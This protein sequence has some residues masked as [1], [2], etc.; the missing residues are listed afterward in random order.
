MADSILSRGDLKPIAEL[1]TQLPDPPSAAT[2]W[3]WHAIGISGVRLKTVRIGGRRYST[4]EAI[5]KFIEDVTALP[6]RHQQES[7]PNGN[8]DEEGEQ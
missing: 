5:D 8:S 6:T 2:L 4:S 3:R 1:A 7:F